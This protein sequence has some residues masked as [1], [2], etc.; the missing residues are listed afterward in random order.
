MASFHY[1]DAIVCRGMDAD[2]SL[3]VTKTTTASYEHAL[4]DV[5]DP[6]TSSQD[7]RKVGNFDKRNGTMTTVS[8][9]SPRCGVMDRS[10]AS[11]EESPLQRRRPSF[12]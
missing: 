6:Q 7:S 10:N 2:G 5:S 11:R 8:K 4:E 1:H 9:R 12:N 3:A